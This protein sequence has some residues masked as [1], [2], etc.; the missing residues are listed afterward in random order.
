[1]HFRVLEYR[2]INVGQKQGYFDLYGRWHG[3]EL[4]MDDRGRASEK[5]RTGVKIE[6]ASITLDWGSYSAFEAVCANATSSPRHLGS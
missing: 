2:I 5:F 1:M 6:H 3:R 4:L